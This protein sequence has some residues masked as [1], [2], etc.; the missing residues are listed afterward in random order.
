MCRTVGQNNSK[1]PKCE[2]LRFTLAKTVHLLKCQ[3]IKMECQVPDPVS[4]RGPVEL[5]AKCVSFLG[6]P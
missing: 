3:E 5:Y 2:R 4:L 6:L 1:K